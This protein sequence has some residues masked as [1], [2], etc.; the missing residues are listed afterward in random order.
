MFRSTHA[1]RTRWPCALS[2][3]RHVGSCELPWR[4]SA[5][6]SGMVRSR[7]LNK[8]RRRPRFSAVTS[9]SLAFQP[10]YRFRMETT[11]AMDGRHIMS[12]S[13]FTRAG[14]CLASCEPFSGSA[15]PPTSSLRCMRNS[16]PVSTPF[17]LR[18]RLRLDESSTSPWH[19]YC[20]MTLRPSTTDRPQ[21]FPLPR[22]PKRSRKARSSPFSAATRR[23]PSSR[24]FTK[25][26][27]AS[28]SNHNGI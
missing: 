25:R 19:S 11:T 13:R 17:D 10:W 26:S 8:P 18:L 28:K 20:V 27:T 15:W 16:Q 21:S 1:C 14:S 7:C 23:I 9:S 12:H 3:A 2:Q 4:V 22:F 6:D 24:S 5:S